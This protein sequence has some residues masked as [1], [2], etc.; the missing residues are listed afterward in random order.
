[1]CLGAPSAQAD[2]ISPAATAMVVTV[3][4][5][6][7]RMAL[8]FMCSFLL[9]LN[10]GAQVS[11]PLPRA[12]GQQDFPRRSSRLRFRREM[13]AKIRGVAGRNIDK[14]QAPPHLR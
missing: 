7:L 14:A 13:V 9:A 8:T 5:I 6:P 11:L 12:S 4:E 10:A 3:V 1:F 2:S